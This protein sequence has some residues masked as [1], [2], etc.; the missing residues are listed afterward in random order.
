M[1]PLLADI[2]A[3]GLYLLFAWMLSAIVASWLSNRA[4]YGERLGLGTGLLLTVVGAIIWIVIY[5]FFPR[6]G[7]PRAV[8]GIRPARRSVADG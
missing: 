5:L 3:V 2:G 6:P 1:I 8:E 7:S 4:G